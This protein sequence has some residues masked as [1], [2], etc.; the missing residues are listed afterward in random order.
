MHVAIYAYCMHVCTGCMYAYCVYNWCIINDKPRSPHLGIDEDLYNLLFKR[1]TPEA[2]IPLSRHTQYLARCTQLF[3]VIE[4]SEPTICNI[5]I[6]NYT[7]TNSP[8]LSGEYTNPLPCLGGGGACNITSR[9]HNI[10]DKMASSWTI[11]VEILRDVNCEDFTISLLST[12][13]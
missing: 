11:Y 1:P 8:L 4:S 7:I 3:T 10:E 6:K 2:T 12:K 5:F 9:V 13:F